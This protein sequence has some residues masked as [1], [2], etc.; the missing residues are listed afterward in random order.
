MTYR[1]VQWSTGNVGVPAL[2]GIISHPDLQ[3]VGL[4]VHSTAKAGVDAGTLCGLPP[5]GVTATNDT[6]AILALDADCVCYTATADLRPWEAVEDICKILASGKN[7]VSS[8]LVQLI[9]P[10]TSD[11]AMVGRLEEACTAGQSTFF[12]SGIDPGFANDVLPIF[13]TGVCERIDSVRVKEILNYATYSQPEV[14]FGTMGFGKPLDHTP[15]LLFPGALTYAWSGPI[16][17]IAEALDVKVDEIVESYEK[18]S[19]DHDVEID[20]GRIEAG[21]MAALRFEVA[22]MVA[23][24]KAII[25]EHVTR[26]HDDA[27]PDWPKGHGQGFYRVEISGSP[28]INLDVEWVGEDGDHNTGGLLV[29]AMRLVNAI[30]AVCDA[31]P[32]LVSAIDLPMVAGRHLMA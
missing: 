25:V 2:H 20:L 7:V 32:G 17:M 22:G 19:L 10:K 6:D 31:A 13:L 3:L 15:L 23:G 26:L 27:A 9:H 8:S 4:W 29:T 11:P 18:A 24:R 12:T 14:L 30:P 16:Q 1:V 21:T 5:V 28:S